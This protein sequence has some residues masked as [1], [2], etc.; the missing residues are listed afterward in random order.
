MNRITLSLICLLITTQLH[1]QDQIATDTYAIFEQS[2]NI[3]H[4][5][6]GAFRETLIIEH[7]TLIENRTVVPGNPNTSELYTRLLTTNIA[8]RM[9]LGQ[10]QLP[11]QAINTI[12]EWILAGAPNW[13]SNTPTN[14]RFISHSEILNTIQIHL[15]SL[16]PFDRTYARY[17]TAAHLYNAG[18]STQILQ[19]YRKGL[20][21]LINSLS[22]GAT[23]INPQSIDP[24]ETIFYIDLRHYEWDR[25]NAWTQLESVYPYHIG[26]NAPTQTKLKAQLSRLQSQMKCDIPAIHTDWF[27]A[28]ASTPPLYHDLLSLPLTDREL[29]TRLE[30]DVAS[31]IQNAPGIRV[32]RAGTN[33]SGVSNHNRAIERHTSRYGAYWKSYDFAGSIGTQNIFTHPLSFT[34]DGGEVIFNLPNGLQGY[35]ITNANGFR[36]DSAPIQ[37]V[38][39]PAAS[40][41]TVRN[42]ISCFGCHTEGM[43]TFKDEVRA[44]IAN[45]TTPT[46]DKAQALRLYVEQVQLDTLLSEDINRY[47][48]AIKA[49]G[50]SPD[51]IEPIARFHAV[52]QDTIDANYAAAALGLETEALLDKIE[53]NIGLQNIGLLALDG[54]SIKRDT[55]TTG[56]KDIIFALDFPDHF[57]VPTPIQTPTIPGQVVHIPDPN[58]RAA[59]AEEL[60]KSPNAAITIEDM[61]RLTSL[62]AHGRDI[63]DLT[64]LQLATNLRELDIEVNSITDL[65][66][67]AGLTNLRELQTGSNPQL[68]NL[69]PIAGL[70]NLERLEFSRGIIS[71]ISPLAGLV[72]LRRIRAWNHEISDISPLARL[73]KLKVIDF[74]GGNISDPT[75]LEGLTGLK[76]L[77]LAGEGVSDI[78]PIANLT[79]LTRLGLPGNNISDISPLA[80]LT[81]L[82]WLDIHNNEISD[83]SPLDNLSKNIKIVWYANPAFPE[84]GPKIQGPWLWL[85]LYGEKLH[86]HLDIIQKAS[87]GKIT[88]IEVAT[89]GATEGKKVGDATWTANKLPLTRWNIREMLELPTNKSTLGTIYGT[90]SLYSPRKQETT[91]YVGG[92]EGLRAYLNGTLVY[93]RYKDLGSGGDYTDFFT[94]TLKEGINILLVVLPLADLYIGFEPGTEY[95]VANPGIQYNLSET[96]IFVGDT[97]TINIDVQNMFDLAGWQFEVNFDPA[98]LEVININEGDLLKQN[99]TTMFLNGPPNNTAGKITGLRSVRLSPQGITGTGTILQIECKAKSAGETEL[100]LNNV[101]FATI[102]GDTIPAGPHKTIINIEGELATGDVN[103]DGNVDTMDLI[104]IAQQLGQRVPPNSPTDVNGDGIINT[105]DLLLVQQEIDAA[106]AAPPHRHVDTAMIEAWIAKAQLEDDGSLAFKQ[107]IENLKALLTTLKPKST[108]LLANYPN[109]FNPETWIPYQLAEPAEVALTIYD[110][111]GEVVR[112]MEIGY[113]QAGIYHNRSHAI[114]WD[115]KNQLGETIASGIYFYKLTAEE[116]T[117]TKRMVILK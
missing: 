47:S 55:W 3:C 18:E 17:F 99:A 78:S 100:T 27:I 62:N 113:K 12:H 16:T 64:G 80:N 90:L 1:A 25:N 45:N 81:N 96:P 107:G 91:M 23:I 89:N 13:E 19:E 42:G 110:I 14:R 73:T 50:S 44:V 103:R 43:K 79:E 85:T 20:N 61:E 67:I 116:F 117:E 94:V 10:P 77:Y 84:G 87:K 26:F 93:E 65:S 8:K 36:L 22:W 24:Q 21:K 35:Y 30:V 75:P 86:S 102:T 60:G 2:C 104:L 31:N 52:F 95:T 40:D 37:I 59:I 41:P 66:A 109:P 49:T 53:E 106:A 4:G 111:N 70:I 105:T 92:D 58:L 57:K 101:Q 68:S 46:F 6:N 72:N 29:E 115:G 32:W 56:F 74:C 83:F 63:K 76:E 33:N 39:N 38:S 71:D 82:K 11:A 98:T 15:N 97:F 28:T 48:T 34:H 108:K 9:P 5:P 51:D 54:G 88:E 112:H 69:S 114:H 7:N